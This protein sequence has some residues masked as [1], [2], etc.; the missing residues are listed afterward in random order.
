MSLSWSEAWRGTAAGALLLAWAVAAHLG[1]AGVGSA[2]LNA[3]MATTPASSVPGSTCI[4][5]FTG[6]SPPEVAALMLL[7]HGPKC[8]RRPAP[9]G[10][11]R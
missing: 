8:G 11:M 7:L 1:S 10:H 6:F 3:A 9:Q 4:T 2:D 5:N